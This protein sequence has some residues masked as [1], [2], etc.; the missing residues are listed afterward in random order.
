MEIAKQELIVHAREAASRVLSELSGKHGCRSSLL[1]F[2]GPLLVLVRTV[3][4]FHPPDI[5]RQMSEQTALDAR[6]RE[7]FQRLKEQFVKDQEV[8]GPGPWVVLALGV[9]I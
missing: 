8:G 3:C 7:Q 6:K 2:W 1:H 9:L 4:A 5:D